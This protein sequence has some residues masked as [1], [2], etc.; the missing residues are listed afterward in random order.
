MRL[1]QTNFQTQDPGG[2]YYQ[3]T[4]ARSDDA[5]IL[6]LLS[7]VRQCE[8]LRGSD[9]EEGHSITADGSGN[10]F[11]YGYTGSPISDPGPW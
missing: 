4:N 9:Y 1:L 3:G 6:N 11:S 2:A 5:F 10:I 7:G 8:P